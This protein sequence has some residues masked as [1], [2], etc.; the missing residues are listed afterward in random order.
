MAIVVD[1]LKK[2]VIFQPMKK[3]FLAFGVI[4]LSIKT[5]A[6]ELKFPIDVDPANGIG[7]LSTD[8]TFLMRVGFRMQNRFTHENYESAK[9]ISEFMTRRARLKL[10]GH[11]VNPNFIYALQLSFTRGDQDWDNVNFP[12]ILRDASLGYKLSDDHTLFFGLRKLPGNRQRVI[13]SGSQEFVDRALTNATFNIDRDIGLQT[14]SKFGVEMPLW[15]KLAITN[16]G[17]RGQ[18]NTDNGL[19]YT[20][21]LEWLPLGDFKSGGD[22]FEGDLERESSPKVSLGAVFSLNK[23]SSRTGGQIGETLLASETRNLSNSMFDF[24][25]KYSGFSTSI[26]WFKRSLSNATINATQTIYAGTGINIQSSYVFENQ[27][28]PAIRWTKISPENYYQDLLSDKEQLTIAISKYIN[29]H[30]VKLQTDITW[31]KDKKIGS[32]AKNNYFYRL[33]VELGI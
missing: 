20:A 13:S 15:V 32:E 31:E 25:F 26:E 4:I 6:E 10:D 9:D 28:S 1:F 29:K 5:S 30:K 16:G 7:L 22:Y 8:D 14:Y 23:N 27:I 3:L 33:Q 24:L 21:R 2:T 18:K 17:G 11:V 12:N 19:A